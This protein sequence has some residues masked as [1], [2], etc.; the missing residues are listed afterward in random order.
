MIVASSVMDDA[1]TNLR[2]NFNRGTLFECDAIRLDAIRLQQGVK[3]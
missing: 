1:T 3:A 2:Q